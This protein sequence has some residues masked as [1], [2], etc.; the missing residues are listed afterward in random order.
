MHTSHKAVVSKINDWSFP[1]STA[2]Y[3]F[4]YVG[5]CICDRKQILKL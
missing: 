3:L 2:T 4:M 5:S 1:F